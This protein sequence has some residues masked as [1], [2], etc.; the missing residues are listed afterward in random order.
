MRV[1][2]AH[3]IP[4][5]SKP[6]SVAKEY[7]GCVGRWPELRESRR[8]SA[9]AGGRSVVLIV[10]MLRRCASAGRKGE[11]SFWRW[12]G[13]KGRLDVYRSGRARASVTPSG[14]S[15]AAILRHAT[16]SANAKRVRSLPSSL[17]EGGGICLTVP[18]GAAVVPPQVCDLAAVG[19]TLEHQLAEGGAQGVL[20]AQ[21][22]GR[23]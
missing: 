23:E 14:R 11:Q 3:R 18:A 12:K 17:L 8:K 20:L 2:I 9:W 22:Y 13:D 7:G 1:I 16:E 5:W 10:E 21:R 19:N 4:V 6:V 15:W